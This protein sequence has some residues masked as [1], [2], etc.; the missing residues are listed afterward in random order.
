MT[1]SHCWGAAFIKMLTKSSL[2]DLK[3]GFAISSF[4]K[5]FRDAITVSRR[6]GVR[7]LWIDSLCILQ[8]SDCIDDWQKKAVVMGDVYKNSLCNIGATGAA[9][10]N[11]GC[12]VDRNVSLVRPCIVESG[13]SGRQPQ[14]YMVVD[15][16]F[17]ARN[18]SENP[19]NRRAWVVQECLLA[20]RVLHFGGEQI[21]WE[22]NELAACETFPEGPLTFWPNTLPNYKP[23]DPEISGAMLSG[24]GGKE[25]GQILNTYELWNRVV[26]TYT[27]CDL[28]NE[29][30]KLVALSGVAKHLNRIL[31]D[32]YLAG[33]WKRF[34]A[35]QLLWEVRSGQQANG[36]P[37]I[38]PRLYRA[39]SWSWASVQGVI[40]HRDIT[41]N[42]IM[43][44]V[45]DA[46]ITPLTSDHTGQI[47]DGY[48]RVRGDLF[49]SHSYREMSQYGISYIRLMVKAIRLD[50]DSDDDI[51]PDVHVYDVDGTY[52]C[53][54]IRSYFGN[55]GPTL[56]GLVLRRTGLD[57]GQYVR[58]GR[59]SVR[60]S[61]NC[62]LFQIQEE[63]DLLESGLYQDVHQRNF[64][65][66]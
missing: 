60:A 10:S 47:L 44:T 29:G 17:W 61:E 52:Y 59:F 35:C 56:E 57:R 13:W 51:N 45:L 58:Y 64:T 66:I 12:F 27:R 40:D 15:G 8:D 7:Y 50:L 53:L 39:P 26:F 30:D 46:Y 65:I 37:S 48:I 14:S 21:A 36:L 1:L 32:E 9:D 4:P 41:S 20:S 54:P 3:V 34:L 38:R 19:L 24:A 6:F 33:L 28:T 11:G 25:T 42:G 2:A 31:K 49:R 22:C 5:T 62:S 55:N 23:L 16:E 18:V 63:E 43:I